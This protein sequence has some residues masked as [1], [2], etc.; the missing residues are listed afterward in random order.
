ML[1]AASIDLVPAEDDHIVTSTLT[2]RLMVSVPWSLL[3]RTW[4]RS[5][6]SV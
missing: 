4:M 3:T 2:I 5:A 6:I 1:S